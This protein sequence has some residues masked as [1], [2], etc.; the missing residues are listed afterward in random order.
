MKFYQKLLLIIIFLLALVTPVHGYL[1]VELGP[2][3]FPETT[4]GRPLSLASIYIG[5]VDT[6]PEVESNQIA[7]YVLQEDGTRVEVTQPIYTNAG[8]VPV[9]DGSPVTLLVETNYSLKVLDANGNQVYYIPTNSS[10]VARDGNYYYPDYLAAD[11][12]VT[13]DNNTIK[14]FVDTIGLV[15]RAVIYFRN[16]FESENTNYVL[17]TDETIPS[18]ITLE[19][20]EGARISG[21]GNLTVNSTTNIKAK[22]NQQIKT[23]TGTLSFTNTGIRYVDWWGPDGTDDNI[24]IGYAIA[25]ATGG[26]VKVIAKTYTLDCDATVLL[27]SGV[28]LEGEGYSSY[29]YSTGVRTARM[30]TINDS[31]NCEITGIRFNTSDDEET[32]AQV[33]IT[34]NSSDIK[35]YDNYFGDGWACI[36]IRP[37]TNDTI[38]NIEIS[39]NSFL[40][41]KHPI[42]LG[43]WDLT[44]LPAGITGDT[45]KNIRILNNYI[46]GSGVDGIKTLQSCYDLIIDSNI[47]KESDQDA[48]DL[49]ASGDKI[50]I[51]NN[52]LKDCTYNGL[53]LKVDQASYT[54]AQWGQNRKCTIIGNQIT[55][56]QYNIRV[57]GLAGGVAPD[58]PYYIEISSNLI[59]ESFESAGILC[60]SNFVSIIGNMIVENGTNTS[61]GSV[62]MKGIDIGGTAA[63]SLHDISVIGNTIVNQGNSVKYGVGI[64]VDYTSDSIL[65]EGNIIRAD[66]EVP[67]DYQ[68]YGISIVATGLGVRLKNNQVTGHSVGNISTTAGIVTGETAYIR[69]GDMEA[70]A[71]PGT[72]LPCFMATSDCYLL[73]AWIVVN[74]TMTADA[75]NNTWIVVSDYDSHSVCGV[76]TNTNTITAMVPYQLG[77]WVEAYRNV[78]RGEALKLRVL[79][80]NGSG[81]NAD[82][83]LLCIEYA[84]K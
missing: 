83:L 30:I 16:T 19:F 47:I 54:P 76:V 41:A 68:D 62:S 55:G 57:Y 42:V 22:S 32:Y 26:T 12:G 75:G 77:S 51:S 71:G 27:T 13:G 46:T 63:I 15:N 29:F 9:Y 1:I 59:A 23:G 84:T 80:N 56:N 11:Q 73:D 70:V 33:E 50:I 3:Y 52:I 72:V 81:P 4:R 6:D 21:A 58:Y 49:F 35:I 7:L 5:E 65:I 60:E 34:G 14:Y 67:N 82:E 18:N 78:D 39:R 45:I 10:Q 64:N 61:S 74:T 48:I 38:S 53:D 79:D 43:N 69:M 31:T 36:H 20:E 17:T 66:S 28:K 37:D 44:G 8:G 40:S 2:T 25:S 24:E